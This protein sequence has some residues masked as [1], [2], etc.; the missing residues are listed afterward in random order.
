MGPLKETTI[1]KIASKRDIARDSIRVPFNFLNQ[2]KVVECQSWV[3]YNVF[4]LPY[5]I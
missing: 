4:S 3:V 5:K 2:E 1:E